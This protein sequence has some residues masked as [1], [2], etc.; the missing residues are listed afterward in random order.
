MLGAILLSEAPAASRIVEL[1]ENHAER[2]D[3]SGFPDH[4]QR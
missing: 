1:I 3:G 2:F 4:K